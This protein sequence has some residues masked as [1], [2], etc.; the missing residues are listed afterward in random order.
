[1]RDILTS[2]TQ[3]TAFLVL[4]HSAH[5]AAFVNLSEWK[6]PKVFGLAPSADTAQV[7]T[8]IQSGKNA[9]ADPLLKKT[10]ASLLGLYPIMH[11]FVGGFTAGGNSAEIKN[12]TTPQGKQTLKTSASY[13]E[14]AGLY[15]FSDNLSL[16]VA[17]GFSTK[18]AKTEKGET[19]ESFITL[20]SYSVLAVSDTL[21]LGLG[22][23]GKRNDRTQTVIP[24]LGGAWQPNAEF[25]LDG[26]LPANV[27]ARWKYSASQALFA[28]LELNGDTALSEHL[29]TSEKT[30]LQMLGA[31]FLMGWSIGMPIGFGTGSVRVDPSL[32]VFKG[33][34]TQTNTQTEKQTKTSTEINPVVDLR[35]A[36]AF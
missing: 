4:L 26:W 35:V 14:I 24:L 34:L 23:S 12:V 6:K 1:M 5:A 19:K 16:F 10:N 17:P 33:Q 18:T 9:S 22:L 7:G 28:R 27:H 3:G 36:V 2:V 8:M 25:R 29:T 31:Q 13:A 15:A 11:E 21:G 20:T 32:G 30:D